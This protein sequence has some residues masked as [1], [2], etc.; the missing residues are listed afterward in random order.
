MGEIKL[1]DDV[2]EQ[3]KDFN[4]WK[5]TKEQESLID[6]LIIDKGLNERYK[7]YGVCKN[8]KK[9]NARSFCQP[10]VSCVSKRFQQNFKNWTSGN[11]VVDEFI[12]KVQLKAETIYHTI[13]W[14]EYDKFEDVEY[15]AKGGFGTTF[16]AVWKDG[17]IWRCNDNQWKRVGETKV[18][19][20]C[21]HNSQGITTEFLKEVESNILVCNSDWIVRCFGITK[22]PKTNNFM[23]VMDLM[24]GGLRQHLNN[25][26]ISLDW[27]KK[28]WNLLNIALGLSDIHEKGLIHHDFHCGNILSN[29]DN[30][31]H[32]TDL[33]LSQPAN[34]KSSQNNN[35]KIYG[36][37]PYVA[38]EV[39]RGKEYTQKSDI[40]GFGIIAYEICTGFPP[41][42]DIAHDEFLAMK[43][44]KG[45]RPKSNY[46]IPQL[47]FDIINQC[48]DADPLKRPNAVE[49]R[50][51]FS[52]LRKDIYDNK[53]DSVIYGQVK[54]ADDIN[55]KLSFSSPLISTGTIS[56]T[57]HPQAVYT[58]RLL[59]F[60]NLPEPKNADNN[61]DLIEYSDSL[62]IDFT[63][64]DINSKDWSSAQKSIFVTQPS[65]QP[66]LLFVKK[67]SSHL[68]VK[69]KSLYLLL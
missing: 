10:C 49:L 12:Q 61:N 5:L 32:I 65:P 30:R 41:Y 55:K 6:E 8:C 19:L 7:N 35:K 40:Y 50:N 13:E 67:E 48:W 58:S 43:I 33:G 51:L 34:V 69:K 17:P 28:L 54:E 59:D 45:L 9:I 64:L 20:K 31:A 52:N 24:N 22:D 38:P 1:S 56:Y 39:L 26:F 57:T 68:F 62:K 60:K 46:K 44:C 29:F 14:I 2:F 25:N 21:L 27:E 37:L 3:I 18:A 42:Y 16:K 23:M 63:K 4:Y 11:H 15:L 47:I 53:M 66:E 36:V